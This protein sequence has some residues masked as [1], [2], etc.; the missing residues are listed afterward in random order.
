MEAIYRDPN[1][2]TLAEHELT[3]GEGRTLR[4]VK[5]RVDDFNDIIVEVEFEEAED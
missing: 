5:A 2:N 1:G 3:P 4:S